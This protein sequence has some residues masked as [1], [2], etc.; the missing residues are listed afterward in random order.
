MNIQKLLMTILLFVG[1]SSSEGVTPLM[2]AS[3]N[4]NIAEAKKLITKNSIDKTSSYGWTALMF[5]SSNGHKNV[6]KLLLKEGANPN[7]V[8]RSIPARFETTGD[9]PPTTALAEAIKNSHI[10]IAKMLIEHGASIDRNAIA[11]S[12]GRGDIDLV[13]LM[14]EKGADM[15]VSSNSP[16][17]LSALSLAARGGKLD[18]I[19]FLMHNGA[20]INKVHHRSNALAQAVMVNR[21][22]TVKYLLEHKANPNIKLGSS[23]VLYE[24]IT[25]YMKKED[26]KKNEEIVKLLMKYGAD[27]F[28][29]PL[30]GGKTILEMAKERYDN[31]LKYYKD[32]SHSQKGKEKSLKHEL[33]IIEILETKP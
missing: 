14:M 19:K 18:M 12:G 33:A 3:S 11:F 31:S 30:N 17:Y 24:A 15:D 29:E 16:F 4:G 8:S 22:K 2:K 32:A 10:S 21:V 5:A 20:N 9:T 6:V 25:M 26:Y 13:R 28:Y 1:C 27:K 7:I 23:S